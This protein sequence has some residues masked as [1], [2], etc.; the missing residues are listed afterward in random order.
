[1][2][3]YSH[4]IGFSYLSCLSATLLTFNISSNSVK[5]IYLYFLC[6]DL[7]KNSRK[8]WQ[9]VCI[10]VYI[11]ISNLNENASSVLLLNV[12]VGCCW[13]WWMTLSRQIHHFLLLKNLR[14]WIFNIIT[15]PF[16]IYWTFSTWKISLLTHHMMNYINKYIVLGTF[17]ACLEQ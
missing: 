10:C 13:F 12:M 15:H 8:M 4:L 5:L 2:A 16:V 9:D 11:Y 14:K 17:L 6:T 1:M 7:V 3:Y